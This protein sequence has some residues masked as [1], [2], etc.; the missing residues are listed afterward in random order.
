MSERSENERDSLWQAIERNSEFVIFELL[1]VVLNCH[2]NAE[3]VNTKWPPWKLYMAI[4]WHV[5]HNHLFPIC[6]AVSVDTRC[7]DLIWKGN[8]KFG[9][10]KLEKIRIDKKKCTNEHDVLNLPC[11]LKS[12]NF[13]HY[14]F[15]VSHLYFWSQ[16]LFLLLKKRR[17]STESTMQNINRLGVNSSVILNE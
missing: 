8:F 12:C 5:Q 6:I 14:C 9:C 15:N 13:S 4:R 10:D 17:H 11:L 3:I 1:T 16:I 2:M 7:S